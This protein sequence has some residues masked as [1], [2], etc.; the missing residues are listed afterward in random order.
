MKS[1][2][3]TWITLPYPLFMNNDIPR[4]ASEARVL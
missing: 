3:A 4:R 2:I 1:G